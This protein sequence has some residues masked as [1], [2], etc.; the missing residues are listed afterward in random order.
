ML[1]GFLGNLIF[2]I[3]A[4]MLCGNYL[5]LPFSVSNNLFKNIKK[6]K[7]GRSPWTTEFV[8]VKTVLINIFYLD[9]CLNFFAIVLSIS[10]HQIPHQRTLWKH[11][12]QHT[13]LVIQN[14]NLM[15]MKSLS[16]RLSRLSSSYFLF[17]FIFLLFWS[18]LCLPVILQFYFSVLFQ[19]KKFLM[20]FWSW[21][22]QNVVLNQWHFTW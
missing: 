1:R 7:K 3:I 4:R 10:T 21:L 13:R 2:A 18:I 11:R 19:E 15:K 20:F 14:E 9:R 16:S 8:F 17:I 6:W 5:N 22:A 12:K